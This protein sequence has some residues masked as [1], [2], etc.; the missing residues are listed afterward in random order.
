MT[1]QMRVRV[2]E[3]IFGTRTPVDLLDGMDL[4]SLGSMG[5]GFISFE[6]RPPA[7]GRRMGGNK[8]R[9]VRATGLRRRR[10]ESMPSYSFYR[11]NQSINQSNPSIKSINQPRQTLSV[12]KALERFVEDFE[13]ELTSEE[14][15][16]ERAK[17]KCEQFGIGA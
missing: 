1:F 9:Q 5:P 15:V 6:Q 7:G 11:F 10:T 4:G 2:D 8:E 13:T 3:L 16:L 17:E 12:K 14:E